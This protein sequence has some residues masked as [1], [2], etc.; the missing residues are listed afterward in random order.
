MSITPINTTIPGL[1]PN[2][3]R[4][5]LNPAV[6]ATENKDEPSPWLTAADEVTLAPQPDPEAVAKLE[7]QWAMDAANTYKPRERAGDALDHMLVEV[8][9]VQKDLG[10]LRPDIDAASWDFSMKNGKLVVQ[11]TLLRKQDVDWLSSQLNADSIMVAAARQFNAAAATYYQKTE[12]HPE[13][14]GIAAGTRTM[15]AYETGAEQ[16]NGG[17]VPFKKLMHKWLD[18]V[19]VGTNYGRGM[20]CNKKQI[21]FLDSMG[22]VNME[23]EKLAYKK[24][25][26]MDYAN[27]FTGELLLSLGRAFMRT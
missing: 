1:L 8:N 23:G 24:R 14:T 12:D 5:G 27:R 4:V 20:V 21:T 18:A 22:A 13:L 16:V 25:P 6:A 17:A 10:A 15:S 3:T 26:A 11:S 2:T 19:R 9:R 7:R